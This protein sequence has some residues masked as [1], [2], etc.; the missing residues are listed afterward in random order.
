MRRYLLVAGAALATGLGF[1][2]V[3]SGPSPSGAAVGMSRMQRFGGRSTPARATYAQFEF[4]PASGAGMGTACA[5]AAVTGVRGETLSF[6]RNSVA[7]CVKGNTLSGIANG[8]LVE[9]SANQPRVMPGGDGTGGLGLQISGARTNYIPDSQA[10]NAVSWSELKNTGTVT[11]TANAAVAPDG[12]TTAERLQLPATSS[13]Q[14]AGL[15]YSTTVEGIH[16]AG[17]YLKGNGTS[18][19]FHLGI[20]DKAGAVYVCSSCT[21][22]AGS[23]TRCVVENVPDAQDQ[24]TL[25]LG[26]M[27][28]FCGNLGNPAM[29]AFDGYVWQVDHQVGTT[30]AAPIKTSGGT[31]TRPAE[32]ASFSLALSGATRSLAA[33]WVPPS[34]F[35][36]SGAVRPVLMLS[37]DADND[38]SVYATSTGTTSTVT[39]N[40]RIAT[41]DNTRATTATMTGSVPARLAAYYDGTNKAACLDG[42]CL[43]TAA[44][45]TLMTG[46]ATVHIGRGPSANTEVD[47]TVKRVCIDPSST[48]CL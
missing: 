31:F 47:G 2:I 8:D 21:Y 4:A 17:V 10:L 25:L 7:Y 34:R 46:T 6:S 3:G 1:F 22:V 26:N 9:C 40:F 38:E 37:V 19:T 28:N 42:V 30:I 16:S 23:W 41:T 43:T 36:G 27:G 33:T 24:G 48:R 14:Y 35:T 44:T 29:S 32:L 5:C 39:S 12:T 18:G 45:L 20:Y 15:L 13:A 11:V